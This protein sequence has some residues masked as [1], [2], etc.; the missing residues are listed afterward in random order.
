MYETFITESMKPWRNLLLVH[1]F[2]VDELRMRLENLDEEF[3]VIHDYNPIEHIRYR[4]K[5]PTSIIEKLHRLGYAP[6]IENAKEKIFDIA[7]I[8]VICA[9]QADIYRVAD[10]ISNHPGIDVVKIK[11]YIKKPK[12]NGY[13]SLHIHILYPVY[14][15]DGVERVRVEIQVRTIAMD[16]WASLEHK[17]YYRYRQKAP[18][19]IQAELKGCADMISNLDDRMYNL[20]RIISTYEQ[21]ELEDSK[22]NELDS[23]VNQGTQKLKN[24]GLSESEKGEL[25]DESKVY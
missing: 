13:K 16:F 15:S 14:L 9:F 24:N 21:E 22:E 3:R 12:E 6:T 5:K 7:G 2:A 18:I 25:N 23:K 19:M 4:V 20:K 1:Q 10:H 8:R 11:D 17:I